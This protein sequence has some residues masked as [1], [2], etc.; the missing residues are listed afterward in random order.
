MAEIGDEMED[1]L[2]G[3]EA[4]EE[5]DVANLEDL[6]AGEDS[7]DQEYN[8]DPPSSEDEREGRFHGPDSSWR[9]YTEQER[10]LAATLDQADCNDLSIHLYNAHAL[11][12]KARDPHV[13]L[14]LNTWQSKHP[15]LKSE[16]NGKPPFVPHNGWT[17][18]PLDSSDVPRQREQWGVPNENLD[19]DLGRYSN[20]EPWKPGRG[21][22][23]SVKA[24]MLHRAF[25]RFRQ[26]RWDGS[27][28]DETESLN[29]SRAR[30]SSASSFEPSS[31]DNTKVESSGE[32][33]EPERTENKSNTVQGP[34]SSPERY[35]ALFT[36][37]DEAAGKILQPTV[38]HIIA[39]MDD[40]LIGL[41]KSRMGHRRDG[42][43]SRGRGSSA[44]RSKSGSR[45]RTQSRG[46]TFTKRKRIASDA[47]ATSDEDETTSPESGERKARSR[48]PKRGQHHQLG[49]RD[50]GEVLGMAAMTGWDPAVINRAAQRCAKLFDEK[51]QIRVM[52]EAPVSGIRDQ[53]VE[54]RPE[55]V[56][57]ADLGLET[58]DEQSDMELDDDENVPAETISSPSL[59][60]PYPDCNRSNNPFEHLWRLREHLK[61]THKHT[62][63]EQEHP[64]LRTKR[65]RRSSTMDAPAPA[66]IKA[67]AD[68]EGEEDMYNIPAEAST[69]Q[70]RAVR[71]DGFMQPISIRAARST[72]KATRKVPNRLKKVVARSAEPAP[73][74]ASEGR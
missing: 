7:E 68:E 26:R 61:R 6:N 1:A 24:I 12:Q 3:A 67:E 2:P 25:Q 15:W 62:N 59:Y 64:A 66:N 35:T 70:H 40:L 58:E 47:E 42:S 71:M 44:S 63:V 32:A 51:L 41:H 48:T 34:A 8:P 45:S 16:D 49:L 39:R 19:E 72:D 73:E 53:V 28:P 38:Q 56:Q 5:N 14:I 13:A 20:P 18:W 30:S 55:M 57:T 74:K 43:L 9:H 22:Q 33:S 23:E 17:A 60:C 50:W 4:L 21:L 65:R 52:P 46:R 31:P 36:D 69:G 29:S 54:Y 11:K 27:G 37:D 10:S